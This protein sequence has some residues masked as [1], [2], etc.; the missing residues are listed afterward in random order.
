[1]RNGQG[2]ERTYFHCHIDVC[3][4]VKDFSDSSVIALAEFFMQLELGHVDC[5][6]GPV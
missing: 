1:M 5:E 6:R 2:E 3:G 4:L